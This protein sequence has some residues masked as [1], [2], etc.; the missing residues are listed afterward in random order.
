MTLVPTDLIF[1][2]QNFQT[3][4]PLSNGRIVIAGGK[5]PGQ[6]A[7]LA[8]YNIFASKEG[9]KHV[10]ELGYGIVPTRAKI[11]K[12]YPLLL[13]K[14]DSELGRFNIDG[15]INN[16]LILK[17]RETTDHKL[18][19]YKIRN[20]N[21]PCEIKVGEGKNE[22]LALA[23]LDIVHLRL[24]EILKNQINAKQPP[25]VMIGLIH[26]AIEMRIGHKLRQKAIC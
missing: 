21:A 2:Q 25:Q 3:Y 7:A 16:I 4:F 15:N 6:T 23:V 9:R 19:L 11:P 14:L 8:R 12:D 1:S 22:K 26:H 10:I 20:F 13:P 17:F 18:L 5:R 24:E